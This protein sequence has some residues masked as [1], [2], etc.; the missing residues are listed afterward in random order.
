MYSYEERMK[1]VRLYIEYDHRGAAAVRK[2]GYPTRRT[3]RDWHR[4]YLES[5]ILLQTYPTSSI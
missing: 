5:G 1:A 3:L 2:L 4:E